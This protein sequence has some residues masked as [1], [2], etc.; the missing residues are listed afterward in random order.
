MVKILLLSTIL[1]TSC[2]TFS[3]DWGEWQRDGI[4]EKQMDW[5]FCQAELDGPDFHHKGICYVAQ[6]CRHRKTI[7]GNSKSEC[8]NKVL[9]CAWGDVE[10]MLSNRL[11]SRSI[12]NKGL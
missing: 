7:L 3:K 11:L 4:Q 5:H 8:R 1:F 2:A 9:F 10:C 12:T 6:E